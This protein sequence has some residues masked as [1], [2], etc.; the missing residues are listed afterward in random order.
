VP[1]EYS[2]Q[3]L[4]SDKKKK[5][6]TTKKKKKNKT[7]ED[8]VLTPQGTFSMQQRPFQKTTTNQNA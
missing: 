8:I 4:E 1:V 2:G 3:G 6:K 5:N 7:Q